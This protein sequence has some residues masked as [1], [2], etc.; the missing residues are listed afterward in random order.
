MPLRP[1]YD[2]FS[3]TCLLDPEQCRE[4][5]DVL[6]R[7]ETEVVDDRGAFNGHETWA[8][9]A[10]VVVLNDD[11]DVLLVNG[12]DGWRLP[13]SPVKAGDDWAAVARRWVA[14]KT[15][16]AVDLD[17]VER[18]Q[19]T[20]YR[21]AGSA[22]RQTTGYDVVFRA[23]PL[24]EPTPMDHL[25]AKRSSERDEW[26]DDWFASVPERAADD[27]FRGDVEWFLEE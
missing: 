25:E 17:R 11:G 10:A 19:R 3:K 23:R 15:G 26:A 2:G 5:T 7:E 12:P 22:T 14:Q 16:L 1:T 20:S 4:R 8:G 27:A 18:V 21:L 9:T 13:A 24:D 6:F